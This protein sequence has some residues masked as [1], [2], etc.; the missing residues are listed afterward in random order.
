MRKLSVGA[1]DESER[2]D[3]FVA[4]RAGCSRAEARRLID[5]GQVRVDGQRAKKGQFLGAGAEV[6]LLAEPAVTRADRQPVP[7]PELPL[8]VLFAD[9]ALVAMVKPIGAPSHPIK[10]G[11]RGTLANALV[12]RFPECAAVSDD[13]R[14]G[15]L[16]HRLDTDTSGV[17][18]AARTR[19]DWQA[20]R[21]AFSDGRVHKEYW[22]LV[23]GH[24]PDQG[25]VDVPLRQVGKLVKPIPFGGA[26]ALPARTEYQ[27]RARGQQVALLRVKAE[28]GRMHQVRAHLAFAGHPLVGDARYGGP[29]PPAGTSGH[30]LHAAEIRFPHPRSGAETVLRAPLPDERA[31]ALHDLLGWTED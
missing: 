14:E 28:T 1:G 22:A 5:E 27:V 12:A 30:F 7:Q 11:E 8:Q 19:D 16:A 21:R 31:K 25:V 6:E 29:P 24:P 23:T 17:I 4:A 2:V 3:R 15:G 20:L 10:P 13:P 26:G 18:L 9:D